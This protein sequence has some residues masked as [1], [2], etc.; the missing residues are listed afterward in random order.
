[1]TRS[2]SWRH[3]WRFAR[4]AANKSVDTN[5]CNPCCCPRLW[6]AFSRFV[7]VGV[8]PSF[9]PSSTK[10]GVAALSISMYTRTRSSS[11][12]SAQEACEGLHREHRVVVVIASLS[13]KKTHLE[14]KRYVANF[15]IKF[16]KINELCLSPGTRPAVPAKCTPV[17]R[18]GAGNAG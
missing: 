17:D 11:N 12:S 5:A 9:Q 13:Q 6:T 10:L 15:R 16:C 7:A 1:M 8:P 4:P 14:H 3:A 18:S 2:R